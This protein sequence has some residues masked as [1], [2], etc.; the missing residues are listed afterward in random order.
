[1]FSR[2]CVEALAPSQQA[3]PM[4][5]MKPTIIKAGT[6]A[7]CMRDRLRRRRDPASPIARRIGRK[8]AQLKRCGIEVTTKNT[9]L[10]MVSFEALIRARET[11]PNRTATLCSLKKSG[12]YC[13]L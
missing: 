10:P 3:S 6:Y 11:F 7:L 5:A 12:R 8:K 13:R 2:A 1:M 4:K 9:N